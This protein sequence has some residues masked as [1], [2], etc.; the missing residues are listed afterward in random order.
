MNA[1]M[2]EAPDVARQVLRAVR[3]RLPQS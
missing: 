2:R 1:L 3:E